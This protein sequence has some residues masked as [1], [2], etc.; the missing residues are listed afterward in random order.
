MHC[1]KGWIKFKA[2]ECK[3]D[4]MLDLVLIHTPTQ[5]VKSMIWVLVIKS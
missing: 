4:K 5:E 1:I 2:I 3:V